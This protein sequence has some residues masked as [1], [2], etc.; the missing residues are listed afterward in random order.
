MSISL[1]TI[2]VFLSQSKSPCTSA[3][4]LENSKTLMATYGDGTAR[5][6]DLRNVSTIADSNFHSECTALDVHKNLAAIGL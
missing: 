2:K 3:S 4:L 6:W 1:Q 5:M